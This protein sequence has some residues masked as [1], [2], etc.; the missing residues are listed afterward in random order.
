M[1]RPR[2]FYTS[3]VVKT[4]QKIKRESC[5]IYNYHLTVAYIGMLTLVKWEEANSIF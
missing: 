2:G 5:Y 4:Y 1:P 3:S